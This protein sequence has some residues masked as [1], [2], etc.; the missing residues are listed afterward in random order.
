MSVR[1]ILGR[2]AF[3]ALTGTT[4]L[5]GA[6][7]AADNRLKEILDRGV[8]RVG[9]QGAF[10]PW[11]FPAADGTLQGIE[12]DLG[13]DVAEKLGVKFEQLLI[14]S[15]NRMQFL[16]QSKIDLIIGGMYDSAQRQKIIGI[17]E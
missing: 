6:A 7:Q 8:L 14:T 9:V 11:S 5:A 17:I 15:A 3:A 2:A 12:V 4:V 13:K 1:S 10:K 16:Q